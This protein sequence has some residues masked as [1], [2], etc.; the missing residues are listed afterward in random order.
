MQQ[1]V[2]S[3]SVALAIMGTT[4][5]PLALERHLPPKAVVALP[6]ISSSAEDYHKGDDTPFGVDIRGVQLIGSREEVGQPGPGIS[7]GHLEGV[8]RA[9]IEAALRPFLGTALSEASISQLQSVV[10]AVWRDAGYPFVSVTVPPQE[11]SDGVLSLRVMEF[12]AGVVE[13]RGSSEP[14]LA[15]VVR[16]HP[17]GRISASAL[18]EDLDW[19]NRNPF[20]QV[21]AQFSPSRAAGASDLTLNVTESKPWS[22]Y[23]GWSNSGSEAT[24]L[25]RWTVGG[26]LWLPMF[27]SASL[28]YRHTRSDDLFTDSASSGGNASRGGYMSHAGTID[29]PLGPRAMFSVAPSMVETSEIITGTLFSFRNRTFELPILYRSAVS[30]V[31]SGHYLGDFYFGITPRWVERT[32]AFAGVDVAIGNAALMDFNFGWAGSVRDSIGYTKLDLSVA[33]NPGGILSDN[34]DAAWVDFTGGRLER[35]GYVTASIDITRLTELSADL[36]WISE[37]T[38]LVAGSALPDPVRLG[39]SGFGAVRGSSSDVAASDTGFVWRNELRLPTLTPL[40]QIGLSDEL[41]PYAFFDLAHGY[42]FNAGDTTTLASTGLGLDYALGNNF[43]ANLTGAV[44]LIGANDAEQGDWSLSA[45][46]SLTY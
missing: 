35:A 37:F 41:S 6:A 39:M 23:S 3:A 45:S 27:G 17:G 2:L 4:A 19:L 30:N 43:K 46:L 13:V 24:G 38:G 36:V 7:L 1:S 21:T 31:L 22:V 10:A 5:A 18:E 29:L 14:N 26:L 40:M 16:V 33:V 9:T 42:D 11:I 20:R 44:N 12:R 32:T 25:A 15:G 8:P 28:G 34:T